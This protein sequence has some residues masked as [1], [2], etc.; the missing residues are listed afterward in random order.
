M[1]GIS[2][3]TVQQ[4][5]QL[6]RLDFYVP[7]LGDRLKD[8]REKKGYSLQDMAEFLGISYQAYRK[9]ERGEDPSI[10]R[11]RQ[12]CDILSCSADYLLGLADKPSE[13]VEL[14]QLR[15]D[16]RNLLKLYNEG[17]IPRHVKRLL[18]DLEFLENKPESPAIEGPSESSA[19]S[20]E[21]TA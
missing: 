11:L 1:V 10:E 2:Y 3:N 20:E 5:R 13:H 6:A 19:S 15:P 16:E 8:L 9:W 4:T 14:D 17:N 7:I 12:I 18:G 21:K